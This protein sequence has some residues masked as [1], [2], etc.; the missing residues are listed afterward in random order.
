MASAIAS[1]RRVVRRRRCRWRRSRGRPGRSPFGRIGSTLAE[2]CTSSRRTSSDGVDA[3]A[4]EQGER[5]CRRAR[6]CRW[7]PALRTSR[8]ELGQHQRRAA[9][10]AGGGDPDL[11]HQLRRPGP[12]GSPPPGGRARRA[13]ARPSRSPSSPSPVLGRLR[14]AAVAALEHGARPPP[15]ARSSSSARGSP[16]VRRAPV[17]RARPLE[18]QRQLDRRGHVRPRAR[19]RRGWPS[20]RRSCPRARR[21]PSSAS[22]GV[23][24]VA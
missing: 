15:R 20:A 8:A 9:G 5:A 6:R 7:R 10:R 3:V 19:S 14:V 21:A 2:V 1:Q 11:L 22:S 4:L 16:I 17:D 18:Q 12:P 13:R 23:P 24:N